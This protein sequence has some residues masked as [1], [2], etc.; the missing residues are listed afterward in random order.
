MHLACRTNSRVGDLGCEVGFENHGRRGLQDG[1]LEQALRIGHCQQ[2]VNG[3]CTSGFAEDRNP[4]RVAAE[5]GD[6]VPHPGESRNL[7]EQTAVGRSAVQ[8]EEALEAQPVVDGH[9]DA[10]LAGEHGAV[11]LRFG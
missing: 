4:L 10:A 11:V 1:A 7:V 9:E 3:A 2:A 8:L 5:S 6:V